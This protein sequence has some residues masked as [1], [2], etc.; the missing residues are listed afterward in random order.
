LTPH[1]D[2][3]NSAP[4]PVN[5][6]KEKV[7]TQLCS[8]CGMCCNGVIFAD[9]K[10]TKT[11]SPELLASRGV[12]LRWRGKTALLSQPCPA[13]DGT[14]CRVYADRPSRCRTFEC[15]LLQRVQNGSVR[16]STAMKR[17]RRALARAESVKT[18]LREL[19]Q[20]DETRPLSVRCREVMMEP[21]DLSAAP[22]KVRLRG[23]LLLAVHALTQSLEED[24]L[25]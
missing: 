12:P 8:S 2:G 16:A 9:L 25:A 23:Q 7:T 20:R 17:I 18:I 22:D 11:D 15:R 13:L 6:S 5:V 24:F 14:L 3:L 1:L 10:L 19:G 21:L 4:M